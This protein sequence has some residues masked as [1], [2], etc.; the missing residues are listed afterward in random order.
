MVENIPCLLEGIFAAK[1]VKRRESVYDRDD[2]WKNL[3]L[4]VKTRAWCTVCGLRRTGKTTLV[5]SVASS[6]KGNLVI[7]INAWEFPSTES[8][9][10]FLERLK[11]ELEEILILSKLKRILSSIKR[12]SVLG[13]SLELKEKAKI[14]LVS[15]LKHL[16][17]R[18][19]LVLI[20]DE[21]QVVLR[22]ETAQKFLT[23]L[24]D[25]L[26]PNFICILMGSVVSLKNA[27]S[28]NEYRPLYGRI[29]EEIVLHPFDERL[30]KGYLIAGFNECNIEVPEEFIDEAV[31]RLGGFPGWLAMLGR[32]TT[33]RM[34]MNKS[35]NLGEI[36]KEIESD[37][38]QI[39]YGEIA[40]L[41]RGR[42]NVNQYLRIIRECAEEGEITV[43]RASRIIRRSPSTTVFYLNTLVENGVLAKRD[44]YYII[45]D[46][47]I[48][49]VARRPEF[50]REVKVRL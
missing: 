35:I 39:I 13:V 48:R 9:D 43:S 1:T 26:M 3:E 33:R 14:K 19:P 41:L 2:E 17:A 28:T 25:T 8:F 47:M 21:A 40:R 29:E 31:M 30:A 12:I 32:I 46:P 16:T 4:F 24:Y 15:A 18:Q 42:K 36:M 11:E 38:S 45:P 37:A 10:F 5:R 20:I 49:R 22:H 34:M 44:D 27:L 50:E 23:A 6:I 7:Y